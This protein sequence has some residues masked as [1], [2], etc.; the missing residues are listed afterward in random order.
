[1]DPSMIYISTFGGGVWH[2]PSAGAQ[3]HA[4]IATPALQPANLP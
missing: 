2:G 1:M 3:G 4:D